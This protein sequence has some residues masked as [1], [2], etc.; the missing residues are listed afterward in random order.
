M[1]SIPV[2][3]GVTSTGGS[4]ERLFFSMTG[5]T[6]PPLCDLFFA[7]KG[8][9][10]PTATVTKIAQQME[11][12]QPQFA[13]DLGDHMFVCFGGAT[14][15]KAQMDAY[16]SALASF[17]APLF[18]T[19]GNHECLFAI[20]GTLDDC[21][22][23][24]PTDPAY[25]TF[26]TALAPTSSKPYYFRDV[27]TVMGLVRFVFIADDAWDTTQADWL[28]QTLTAADTQANYTIVAQHH[29][30]GS[31][32]TGNYPAI[33][34]LIKA[35]KYALH[36]TAHDHLYLHDLAGDPTGRTVVVGTGGSAD[37]TMQG[38]ATVVQGVDGRLYFTMYDSAT[39]LPADS[40]SV[41]PNG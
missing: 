8:Y 18:M 7:G 27:Q 1:G 3:G 5:D 14:E 21:G 17:H 6:R 4:V 23:N 39:N 12:R 25:T 19:M 26:L 20:G 34:A 31:S 37:A 29:S 11:G 13:I 32:N 9:D 30:L 28:Q 38:Y 2:R 16:Q 36:L 15:A 24:N 35:H 40:F 10:Y 41:G 22:A 33:V